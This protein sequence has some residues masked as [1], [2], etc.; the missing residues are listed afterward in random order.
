V[1]HAVWYD[2]SY[3]TGNLSGGSGVRFPEDLSFR[4]PTFGHKL[5]AFNEYAAR[6]QRLLQ[7]GRHVADIG[8]VYPIDYME[9]LFQFNTGNLCH[10]NDC[11]YQTLSVQ[12]AYTLRRDFT[13][14]HPEVINDDAHTTIE[15]KRFKLNNKVN[16][17]EYHTII[18][19]SVRVLN[20]KTVQKI[21]TFY[22]MGGRVI[23]TNQLPYK[24]VAAAENDQVVMLMK[25]MFGIDPVTGNPLSGTLGDYSK[26][27]NANGG[28]AYFTKD[29]P[30]FLQTILD[31]TPLIHD[32]KFPAINTTGESGRFSYIHKVKEG[33]DLYFLANT[34][35][36]PIQSYMDVRGTITPSIWDPHTGGRRTTRFEV[37]DGF[38]RVF[39]DLG[40]NSSIFIINQ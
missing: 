7:Y 39:F 5:R 28:A 2:N 35:S 21:K 31:D 37:R 20:L 10:P 8:L 14:L 23:G 9:S 26:K 18:I 22:D 4:N 36:S 32:V 12:L 38:T 13:F 16:F 40:A 27:V 34:G 15:G 3:G 6:C 30:S 17:E 29:A 25:E 11:N 24:G 19:P 1:P 33:F